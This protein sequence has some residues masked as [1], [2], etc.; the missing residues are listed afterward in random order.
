MSRIFG[1][2]RQIAFVLRSIDQGLRYWTETLGVGTFYAMRE[3]VPE[4]YRYRGES[5]PAPCIS[6]ALGFS[7]GMQVELIEQHDDRPSAYRRDSRRWARCGPRS[8]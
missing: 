1:E 8:Y 3:L 6:L 4:N 5:V 7:G 2:M